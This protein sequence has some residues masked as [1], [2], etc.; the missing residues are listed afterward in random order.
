M[1]AELEKQG[2]TEAEAIRE[3]QKLIQTGSSIPIANPIAAGD[4][5][6][7]LVSEGGSIGADSPFWATK[8]ELKLLKG[9]SYDNIADR[10]GLPLASQQGTRFQ[11]M[12]IT[13]FR[14]NTS[15]T[16][17]IAPTTEIGMNG[18]IWT[19]NGNGLQTLLT[20]RSAFTNPKLLDITFP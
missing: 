16:S 19:Q 15:F 1:V 10:F 4:K 17:V 12:E 11:V 9:M 13:A 2:I 7:K 6:Y 18:V 5:F 3:A 8:D 14:E 20:N